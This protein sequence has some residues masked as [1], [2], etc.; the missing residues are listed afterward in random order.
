[1]N[2][3]LSEAL[4]SELKRQ[5]EAL[6]PSLSQRLLPA[7]KNLLLRNAKQLE[8]WASQLAAGQLTPDDVEWLVRSSMDLTRLTALE[9]AGLAQAD[10][11]HFRQAVIQTTLGMLVGRIT[12]K[13]S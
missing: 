13:S 1:M 10:L 2:E 8:I 7:G 11:D 4:F 9:S 12:M 5:I 3:P 6:L